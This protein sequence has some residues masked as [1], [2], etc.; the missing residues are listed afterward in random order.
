MM[1]L[2]VQ[3]R[4]VTRIPALGFLYGPEGVPEEGRKKLPGS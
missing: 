4:S 2:K 1:S 3:M